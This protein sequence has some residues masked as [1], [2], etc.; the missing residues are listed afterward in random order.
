LF[1]FFL[2]IGL[3]EYRVGFRSSPWPERTSIWSNCLKC[4]NGGSPARMWW[5]RR[6]I[7]STG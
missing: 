2:I 7:Y 3:Q 4:W 1:F 5:C 6:C